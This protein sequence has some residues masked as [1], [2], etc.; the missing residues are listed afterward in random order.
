MNW[1]PVAH[2]VWTAKRSGLWGSKK[3]QNIR[4][5]LYLKKCVNQ[6][7]VCARVHALVRICVCHRV[8][9][10]H[11]KPQESVPSLNYVDGRD[12]AQLVRL[13]R[14]YLY[15]LSHLAQLTPT[16]P[17][18]QLL[19]TKE[20]FGSLLPLLSKNYFL[21]SHHE[22]VILPKSGH[23]DYKEILCIKIQ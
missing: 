5:D 12:W 7:I 16:P 22:G 4:E 9:R 15:Q 6:R 18:L 8:W 2:V 23:V 20:L 19:Q 10:S 17:F 3:T 1:L 11:D 21:I 14:N 13:E